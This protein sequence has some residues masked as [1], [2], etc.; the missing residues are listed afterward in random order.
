MVTLQ[1][2]IKGQEDKFSRETVLKLTPPASLR[3]LVSRV[4]G[5]TGRK[6]RGHPDRTEKVNEHTEQKTE[7]IWEIEPGR[8]LWHPGHSCD[9][10]KV[11]RSE[12]NQPP[13]AT[14]KD[15]QVFSK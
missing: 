15:G 2:V 5:G 14:W 9:Y 4:A 13:P 12:W 6:V 1:I 3:L 11:L 7:G 10:S 8:I